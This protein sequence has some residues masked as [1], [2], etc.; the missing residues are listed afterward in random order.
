MKVSI[1]NLSPTRDNNKELIRWANFIDYYN[2]SE[3]KVCIF[4][5]SN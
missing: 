3:P 1:A 4:K 2:Y 5:R